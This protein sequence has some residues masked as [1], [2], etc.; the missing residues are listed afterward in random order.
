MTVLPIRLLD[1]T[2]ED[3]P[4]DNVLLVDTTHRDIRY[5]TEIVSDNENHFNCKVCRVSSSYSVAR[6]VDFQEK[7]SVWG[8]RRQ[9][10]MCLT[11][12][13]IFLGTY[14]HILN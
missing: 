3:D 5:G 9:P 13:K 6:S 14:V 10:V 7:P 11:P 8:R 12:A 1:E 4:L 2:S